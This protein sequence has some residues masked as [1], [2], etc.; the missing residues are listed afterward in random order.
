MGIFNT[1]QKKRKLEDSEDFE[2]DLFSI[3]EFLATLGKDVKEIYDLSFKIK[4]LRSKERAEVEDKK[5]LKL[6]EKEIKEWDEFLEKF[7]MFDRDVAVASQR[8]KKIS[9]ILA[10]EAD[11]MPINPQ[12]KLM[13]K[14]KDEW[15]FNW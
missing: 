3:M 15:V 10:E 1:L 11:K 12:L 6:L 8:V 5:Q 4:K 9:S 14:K 13:V 7:V 2:K